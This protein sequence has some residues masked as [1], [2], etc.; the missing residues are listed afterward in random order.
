MRVSL[1]WLSEFI[2]LR[3]FTPQVLAERLTLSGLEVSSIEQRGGGLETVVAGRIRTVLPHPNADKLSLTEVE[4]P[5]EILQI[6]CGAKNIAPGDI[7]PVALP[8]TSLPHGV[9]INRTKIRGVESQGMICSESELGLAPTS[10]G[11]MHLSPTALPGSPVSQL[12][13]LQDTL[14]EVEVTPN[15]PDCLSHLGIARHLSAVLDRPLTLPSVSITEIDPPAVSRMK[16]EVDPDA[17]CHRYCARI[18]TDVTVGPS[19]A[20][21][22][23]RLESL[24]IRSINNVVDVTNYLLMEIGHPLHA[25]DL[26]RLEGGVIRARKASAGE[27]ITTLDGTERVLDGSELV[28]ADACKPVALAGVMGGQATEVQEQTKNILLEAAWFD[29]VVVRRMSRQTNCQSESSYRFERGTDPELGLLLALD[30][31]AQLITEHAGGG[32][33]KGIAELYPKRHSA[34]MTTLRLA[35]AEKILGMQL[36]ASSALKALSRLG[37]LTEATPQ[38]HT[39]RVHVP[40]FRSDVSMEEDLIEDLAEVIGYDQIPVRQPLVPLVMPEP[41]L[42]RSFRQAC[43]R[44][45]VGLGLTEVINYSFCGPS[46]W[47]AL[48]LSPDHPW[49]SA[50]VLKNPLSEDFS[51]LRPS[52]LPGLINSVVYNQRR[53]QERIFLFECGAV[54]LPQPGDPLPAEPWRLGMVLSG[55]R[56]P[57]HWRTGKQAAEADFYD[58]KGVLE[59]LWEQLPIAE[60]LT[61]HPDPLPFLH[62]LISYRLH[63]GGKTEVGWAG[64]LHPET[65]E[66]YKSKYALLVAEL[67]LALLLPHWM[68][69]PGLKPFSRFPSVVRDIALAV[70]A[71]T[72]AGE[73]QQAIQEMGQGLVQQVVPFDQYQGE[74]L[75]PATKSLAFSLT[76]QAFDRTLQEE[77]VNVLQTR[78]VERLQQRFGALQR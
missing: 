60:T 64:V 28:I 49:R 22:R 13:G 36:S 52:L 69:H 37:Y 17:G 48:R 5:G 21:M 19:P 75:K 46:Q 71:A 41:N 55:L 44:Q 73:V 38:S 43:R 20:W 29:P 42:S 59:G 15:R 76:F 1:T 67:D 68:R 10:E 39:Y 8:G 25:F 24:G 50:L 63:L 26:D 40:S 35:R 2:D 34:R 32:M 62:P 61:L 18:I 9:Q 16:V 70:P 78:I 6:V 3:D 72:L 77:E 74:G 45:A 27:K 53:G 23:R 4:I 65:Q 54:F 14:L 33:L 56:H 47:A 58:L 12:L 66:H 30:R 31:A 57:K 11:I 7:V 51:L